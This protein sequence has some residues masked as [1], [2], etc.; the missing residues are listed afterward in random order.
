MDVSVD[1]L[2]KEI[3][4]LCRRE[5]ARDP[6]KLLDMSPELRYV[7][8]V[9]EWDQPDQIAEKL[10]STVMR[11][12]PS[13]RS[14]ILL[15][16]LGLGSA[17][18]GSR[19]SRFRSLTGTLHVGER[20]LQRRL[21][22]TIM[23]FARAARAEACATWAA[24]RTGHAME[25]FSGAVS[26]LGNRT[27]FVERR[28]IKVT[29]TELGVIRG[30]GG[31][32]LPAD[33]EA[34]DL[35]VTVTDG[36]QFDGDVIWQGG[37]FDY[38]VKPPAPLPKGAVHEFEVKLEFVDAR[39]A[40]RYVVQPDVPFGVCELL[41]CFDPRRLPVQVWRVDEALYQEIDSCPSNGALLSL[42]PSG[43]VRVTC[44]PTQLG[45]AYG[46]AWQWE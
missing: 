29:D 32:L 20:T 21:D 14:E 44:R 40:P 39:L 34:P 11:L 15:T 18:H 23:V 4:K 46:L 45:R 35:R 24:R 10:H 5:G 41:V 27:T 26:F 2:V 30:G 7:C 9:T 1:A 12:L 17:D 25:A 36:G 38:R 33:G 8:G 22:D 19:E 28:K 37:H 13:D 3:R 42:D 43:R 6:S 16:A 31:I